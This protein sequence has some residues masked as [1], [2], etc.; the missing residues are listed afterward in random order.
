MSMKSIS[1]WAA[2]H[3]ALAQICIVAIYL[4]LNLLGLFT[5][6]L[7]NSIGIIFNPLFLLIP[8]TISILGLIFYP[9]KK[10][11]YFIKNFYIKQKFTDCLL[12][13]ATF[14]FIVF[15]GNS[16]KNFTINAPTS[17]VFGFVSTTSPPAKL[18]TEK[19]YKQSPQLSKKQFRKS[20]RSMVKN[21]R[22]TYKEST[23]TGKTIYIILAILAAAALIYLL[24]GLACSISCAGAEA[25]AYVVFFV[26]LSAI[27]FG[28]VKLIQRITR[29]KPNKEKL[30]AMK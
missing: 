4:A 7:F 1:M 27:V 2:S 28:L 23:K 17:F 25:W 18:I 6:D 19:D 8:L 15:T 3:K 9:S 30:Q 20:I 29:G 10:N 12:A 11:K 26:G 24:A 14:L 21:I 5:G 16:F 22:K 13:V